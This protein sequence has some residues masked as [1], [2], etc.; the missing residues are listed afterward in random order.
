MLNN[1]KDK[2]KLPLGVLN[3]EANEEGQAALEQAVSF[4]WAHGSQLSREQNLT[5]P[6]YTVESGVWLRCPPSTVKPWGLSLR[7]PE[8]LPSDS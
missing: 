6:H 1:R 7:T 8:L 5:I 3:P 4:L 2:E